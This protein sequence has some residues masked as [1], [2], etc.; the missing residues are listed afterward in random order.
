MTTPITCVGSSLPASDG[1]CERIIRFHPDGDLQSQGNRIAVYVC[2]VIFVPLYL[3]R[4]LYM[5]AKWKFG[6]DKIK[7]PLINAG[8]IV[9]VISIIGWLFLLLSRIENYAE[10]GKERLTYYIITMMIFLGTNL[11]SIALIT[12]HFVDY[13]MLKDG[14]L[15]VKAGYTRFTKIVCGVFMVLALFQ[16]SFQAGVAIKYTANRRQ[17]LTGEKLKQ[18]QKI[19]KDWVASTHYVTMGIYVLAAAISCLMIAVGAKITNK[20]IK[21]IRSTAAACVSWGSL[22]VFTSLANIYVLAYYYYA[23]ST[24]T[25]KVPKA[26]TDT[27]RAVGMPPLVVDGLYPKLFAAFITLQQEV[28]PLLITNMLML[29]LGAVENQGTL[30]LL[31]RESDEVF[32]Y[33]AMYRWIMYLVFGRPFEFIDSSDSARPGSVRTH[34][35]SH[36]ATREDPEG[37]PKFGDMS[38]KSP[39]NSVNRSSGAGTAVPKRKKKTHHPT[40]G[41][42]LGNEMMVEMSSTITEAI[43]SMDD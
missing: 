24:V 25:T 5:I 14:E 12:M 20:N 29:V 37:D 10:Q 17:D 23:E 39:R 27:L 43:A 30:V 26:F 28:S 41:T 22:T 32:Y 35:K 21:S 2:V 42:S 8:T 1:T 19:A 15:N 9:C 13:T 6:S 40:A 18:S 36:S 38:P 16:I 3:N 7:F 11:F 4:L 34:S 31:G 33:E